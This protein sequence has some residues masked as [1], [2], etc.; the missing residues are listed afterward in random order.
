MGKAKAVTLVF[1]GVLFSVLG[2]VA[3]FGVGCMIYRRGCAR[4][5]ERVRCSEV[6]S[7]NRPT[8][9]QD[10]SSFAFGDVALLFVKL[11]M[12]V[13]QM[14]ARHRHAGQEAAVRHRRR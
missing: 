3:S 2:P 8:A 4:R 5:Y 6:E 1:V 14:L 13:E 11:V 10:A 12:D 9:Q 7:K